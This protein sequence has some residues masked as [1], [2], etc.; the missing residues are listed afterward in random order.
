MNI[1]YV[2]P[3]SNRATGAKTLNYVSK[4]KMYISSR[5]YPEY[6]KYNPQHKDKFVV[7]PEGIQNHGKSRCLNWMLD[8]LWDEDTDAII[9]LDD[10]ITCLMKKNKGAKDEV[11][12]E[13]EF[14]E[15]CENWTQ[16]A[17]DW[18]IGLWSVALNSDP[19]AYDEF[20]PF[21]TH[22]YMDGAIS[23]WCQNDGIRYTEELTI[24]E[25]IDYALKSWQKY[26]KCLRI[27]RFYLNVDSF[28]DNTGGCNDFRSSEEEKRQFRM[29]QEKWG[30]D[31]I[32]PN[33]SVARKNSKIKGLGGAIK[34]NLPYRG[35]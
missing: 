4:L 19:I 7:V 3:S 14:Y 9:M 32:R 11:V 12:P 20:A 16:L 28:G 17:K 6:V 13:E 27:E 22:A 24:K 25:D 2:S 31:V 15:L 29:M 34:L 26:H 10:D 23:A 18:N 30:A 8:N 21:R 5:D 33:R 1:K 35:V